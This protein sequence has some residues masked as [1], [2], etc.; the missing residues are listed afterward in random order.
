MD[1]LQSEYEALQQKLALLKRDT[2][3]D[4]GRVPLTPMSA[5][6]ARKASTAAAT[7]CAVSVGGIMTAAAPDSIVN[8]SSAAHGGDTGT[9]NSLCSMQ[10]CENLQLHCSIPDTAGIMRSL[11]FLDR[12]P[13]SRLGQLASSTFNDADFLSQCEQALSAQLQRTKDGATAQS[14]IA[15]LAGESGSGLCDEV[16]SHGML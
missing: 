15:E 6:Q 11:Q 1:K 3:R 8:P 2:N 14:R 10:S 7:A 9:L 5:M 12:F 16:I 4:G 13:G